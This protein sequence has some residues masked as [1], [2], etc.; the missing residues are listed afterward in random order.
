MTWLE[1]IVLGLVQGF[2]EF[3]PISSSGHL[4]LFQ[5]WFGLHQDALTFDILLHLSTL[6]AIILFFGK[7]LFKVTLKEWLLVVVGT[8]PAALIGVLFKDQIEALFARDVWVGWELVVTGIIILITDRKLEQQTAEGA[9]SKKIIGVHNLS[10]LDALLIGLGQ[11]V[12]IIPGISRSGTTVATGILRGV[13]R[14]SA[15]RF[16]FL[17]AIPALA[18]AGILQ[19]KDVTSADLQQL[20]LGP[21][22]A[23]C[24]AALVSGLLSLIIF[25]WVIKKARLELFGWYCLAIGAAA[26]FWLR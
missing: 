22:I 7:S 14:E 1:A 24:I 21:V 11:A 23:G 5:H 15:F 6:V 10:W 16:S 20:A 17:L 9:V 2:T 26:I 13:D 4:V 19:L 18:G 25:H 12:A 8:I 3:L